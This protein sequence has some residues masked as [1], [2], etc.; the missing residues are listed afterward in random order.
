MAHVFA[1][2]YPTPNLVLEG[3]MGF[4]KSDILL[5]FHRLTSYPLFLASACSAKEP[6]P[7]AI[8]ADVGGIPWN[9]WL[10]YSNKNA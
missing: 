8:L 3:E 6:L 10:F 4:F 9:S 2:P 1:F 7:A 5:A